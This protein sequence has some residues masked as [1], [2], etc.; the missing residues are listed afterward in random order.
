MYEPKES[1]ILKP[2]NGKFFHYKRLDKTLDPIKAY[3]S[4][5]IPAFRAYVRMAEGNEGGAYTL[6]GIA[7]QASNL[8][9]NFRE[10]LEKENVSKGVKPAEVRA[11][12]P[13]WS[14]IRE[15]SNVEKHFIATL[16]PF[17]LHLKDITD[18]QESLVINIFK[19]EDGTE[20][21]YTQV[22]V[23]LFLMNEYIV[24]LLEIATKV[25]N[26]WGQFLFERGRIPKPEAFV[27]HGNDFLTRQEAEAYKKPILRVVTMKDFDEMEESG[28][29]NV[30][31]LRRLYDKS[32]SQFLPQY[33]LYVAD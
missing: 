11:S 2:P 10:Y 12:C 6:R 24:D 28:F 23:M 18:I 26:F 32:N 15:V 9:F 8:L 14:I 33:Q 29:L 16:D 20:Y 1:E 30:I 31:C 27:Y 17:S 19:D 7:L 25:V 3:Q 4:M 21:E 5:L 22:R 13:E